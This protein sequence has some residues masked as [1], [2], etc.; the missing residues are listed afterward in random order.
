M[1]V[2]RLGIVIAL[3]IAISFLAGGLIGY[4][5]ALDSLHRNIE[6]MSF[7]STTASTSVTTLPRGT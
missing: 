4:H 3:S 6:Y 7:V 2:S 5:I 1:F